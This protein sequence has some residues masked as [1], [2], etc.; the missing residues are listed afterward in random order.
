MIAREF[1]LKLINVK[2]KKALVCANCGGELFEEVLNPSWLVVLGTAFSFGIA[3][4]CWFCW[5]Y[6]KGV[7]F[8]CIYC[9][10]EEAIYNPE[11]EAQE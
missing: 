6:V 9:G 7:E 4:F 5:Q 3:L 10:C 1:N 2:T 8:R 11:K